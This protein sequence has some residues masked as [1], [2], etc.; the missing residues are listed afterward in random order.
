M[1]P[2]VWAGRIKGGGSVYCLS[3]RLVAKVTSFGG[4]LTCDGDLK[5]GRFYL[6]L[7]LRSLEG[8]L[9]PS[10]FPRLEVLRGG[11]LNM[12]E[13]EHTGLLCGQE[14]SQ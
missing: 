11:C 9:P 1:F 12:E 7:V 6:P 13:V 14:A 4:L 2:L 8:S 10:R 3:S 5:T